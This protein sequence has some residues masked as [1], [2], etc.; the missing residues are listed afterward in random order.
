MVAIVHSRSVADL[1]VGFFPLLLLL[2]LL[3]ASRH[4]VGG[5]AMR[6]V[7]VS[8]GFVSRLS[9]KLAIAA[10]PRCAIMPSGELLCSFVLTSKLGTNDFLPVLYRSSDLG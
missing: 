10:G 6:F 4:G 9:E 1:T 3:L 8:E 5:P 7:T 2:L